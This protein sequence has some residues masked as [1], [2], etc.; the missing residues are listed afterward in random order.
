MRLIVGLGGDWRQL[1]LI[2]SL[3][4][5]CSATSGNCFWWQAHIIME[6]VDDGY[7]GGIVGFSCTCDCYKDGIV[8]FKGP[9]LEGFVCIEAGY[10]IM[11]LEGR[12]LWCCS[13]GS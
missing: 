3:S 5:V 8:D 4:A 2:W 12:A 9:Q 7:G 11:V 10:G 1:V 6:I 13:S